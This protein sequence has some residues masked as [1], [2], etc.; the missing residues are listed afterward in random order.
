MNYLKQFIMD[1]MFFENKRMWGLEKQLAEYADFEK[2]IEFFN[3]IYK[4][5]YT[6]EVL[7]TLYQQKKTFAYEK[8]ESYCHDDHFNLLNA[9]A[10]SILKYMSELDVEKVVPLYI[11]YVKYLSKN[12]KNYFADY[13]YQNENIYAV[14]F[15]LIL[16]DTMISIR[17]RPNA[18]TILF[19][20]DINIQV[21]LLSGLNEYIHDGMIKKEKNKQEEEA[22]NK[23]FEEKRKQRELEL[24][25]KPTKED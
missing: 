24:G 4:K 14:I 19:N 1:E 5:R 17:Q 9:V 8:F 12:V 3:D 13:K 21:F 25:P 6:Q 15:E 11:I 20:I 23:E 7:K 16:E 2:G 18:N 10:L 22:R